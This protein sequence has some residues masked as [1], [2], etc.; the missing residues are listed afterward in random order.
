MIS[1]DKKT[2]LME[3]LKASEDELCEFLHLIEDDKNIPDDSW[4]FIDNQS[5]RLFR[6]FRT[7]FDE[8]YYT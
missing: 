1:E 5:Q 3:L 8:I 7:M 6:L 2:V 4:Y